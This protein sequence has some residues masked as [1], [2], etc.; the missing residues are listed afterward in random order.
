MESS[1]RHLTVRCTLNDSEVW[2]RIEV[3][4]PN[5]NI[6]VEIR[7]ITE[8]SFL[9]AGH[10]LLAVDD[11]A[12]LELPDDLTTVQFNNV[13]ALH[14]EALNVGSVWPRALGVHKWADLPVGTYLK[15]FQPTNAPPVALL[16]GP[17]RLTVTTDQPWRG[18]W[19]NRG[20]FPAGG[21]FDH[22]GIE[23]CTAPTDSLA[24]ARE[25]GLAIRLRPGENY[26]IAF[27]LEVD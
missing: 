11:T 17:H 27:Q 20:G 5:L 9:W 3:D 7:A 25:R 10:L 1:A 4:G 24:D 6:S 22:V 13:G 26:R 23:P 14:D 2:R 18:I 19:I 15:A 21:R 8:L 12:R 16:R